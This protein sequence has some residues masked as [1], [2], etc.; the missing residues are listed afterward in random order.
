MVPPSVKVTD[1]THGQ[2][3]RNVSAKHPL[4]IGARPVR[5]PWNKQH[6]LTVSRETLTRKYTLYKQVTQHEQRRKTAVN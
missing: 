2:P 4:A 6:T 3:R 1:G 5:Q